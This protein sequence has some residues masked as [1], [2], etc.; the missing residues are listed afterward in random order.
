MPFVNLPLSS[1]SEAKI[2]SCPA[3]PKVGHASG[4]AGWVGG[5]R[6][7]G[8]RVSFV[9]CPKPFNHWPRIP[10]E[11]DSR[12]RGGLNHFAAP[13]STKVEHTREER[14]IHPIEPTVASWVG[15]PESFGYVSLIKE[16]WRQP[17]P[18]NQ[19]TELRV[20]DRPQKYTAPLNVWRGLG[21][22]RTHTTER[23]V[24]LLFHTNEGRGIQIC[25]G[26]RMDKTTFGTS[27]NGKRVREGRWGLMYFRAFSRVMT[28]PKGGPR[29]VQNL[30]GRA[31]LGQVD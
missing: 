19:P 12:G 30:A 8:G 24:N 13:R 14:G 9:T 21:G 23:I 29:D 7:G 27:K 18:Q 10:F 22:T 5:R 17:P 31:G 6:G 20:V 4:E 16:A 28:Q 2:F 11:T 1:P 3:P 15:C 26:V 25:S